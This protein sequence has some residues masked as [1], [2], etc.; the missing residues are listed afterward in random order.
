MDKKRKEKLIKDQHAVIK[1]YRGKLKLWRN[2][3]DKKTFEKLSKDG[4]DIGLNEIISV[5]ERE[6]DRLKEYITDFRKLLND[7][8]Y[9]S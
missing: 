8:K 3:I 6:E 2:L 5:I 1:E 4:N 9:K 7:I